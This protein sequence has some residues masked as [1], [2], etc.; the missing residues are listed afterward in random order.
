MGRRSGSP[1][2]GGTRACGS[3]SEGAHLQHLP[4]AVEGV[5]RRGELGEPDQGHPRE[6]ARAGVDVVGQ[7]EVDED[8]RALGTVGAR[9]GEAARVDERAGG[10]GAADDEV[11]GATEEALE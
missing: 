5:H 2:D 7:R 10:A 1:A 4:T 11:G 8:D 9:G 6:V 3:A